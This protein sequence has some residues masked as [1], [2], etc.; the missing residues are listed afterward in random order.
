MYAII[1]A[2]GQQIKVEEGQEI[3]I[4]FRDV[5]AGEKITFDRV[6]AYQNDSGLQIGQPTLDSATVTA[7]VL[8]EQKGQ[9]LTVQKFRRRKNSKTKTGHRQAYTKVKIEK[10][11][12]G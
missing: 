12:V 7:E 4:D 5:D 11:T 2:G 10:I 9:K 1:D 3:Q 8:G 6:L